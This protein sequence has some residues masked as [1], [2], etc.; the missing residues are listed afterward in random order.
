MLMTG[1]L[2]LLV[3]AYIYALVPE[4]LLR[5]LDWLLVHSIFRLKT[6]GMAHIPEDGAALLVCNHQS[7]ADALVIAAACRRPIRFVMYYKI[8]RIPV[9]SFVFRSMKA[10][11]IAG[12]KEDAAVM[13][14]AF[15]EVAR[16]LRDGQ[17]VCI[18]PEGGLT[19]DGEIARFRPGI[20]RILERTPVPV[21]PMA[22]SGLWKSIF[23]RNA[24]VSV[25]FAK[26]FPTVR[27]NVGAPVEAA[28]ATPERMH[29]EVRML[30]GER[31]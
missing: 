29:A 27:L 25:P 9:L 12:G 14:K 11:P 31:R 20:V 18:F 10:I 4:F 13:E 30:Q 26:L 7:L 2:N 17:L 8:F 3:A 22:L 5:F 21:I 16:A 6:S 28:L 23:A 15:E 19:P 1:L 24:Q